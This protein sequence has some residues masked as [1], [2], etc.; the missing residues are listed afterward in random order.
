MNTADPETEFNLGMALAR[1]GKL[2]AA[3]TH[4][5]TALRLKPDYSAARNELNRLRPSVIP[6]AKP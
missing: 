2:A 5:A 3:A 6:A 4:Y 1:Q